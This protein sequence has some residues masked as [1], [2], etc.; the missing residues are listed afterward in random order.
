MERITGALWLRGFLELAGLLLGGIWGYR[1]DTGGMRFFFA[2]GIPLVMAIAWG[3]FNV[4]DDPSRGGPSPVP[5][6]GRLRLLLEAGVFGFSVFAAW[7][8]LGMWPALVFLALVLFNNFQLRRRLVWLWTK[9]KKRGLES[10][11]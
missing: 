10:E 11:L 6:G 7:S 5:I 2:L 1:L 8:A 4:P 9:K 3:V